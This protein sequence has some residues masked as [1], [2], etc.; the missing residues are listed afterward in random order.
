MV[1]FLFGFAGIR[2]F[3]WLFYL[4]LFVDMGDGR[5]EMGD[6]RWEMGDGIRIIIAFN[7]CSCNGLLLLLQVIQLV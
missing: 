7:L 4:E 1:L 6:G 3:M 2:Y 5:W